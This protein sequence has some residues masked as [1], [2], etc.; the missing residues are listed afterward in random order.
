MPTHH[1]RIARV[2]E[3]HGP[4]VDQQRRTAAEAEA[5]RLDEVVGLVDMGMTIKDA[6]AIIFP[7]EKYPTM[8]KRLQAYREGGEDALYDKH[9]PPGRDDLPR[10][11]D[12]R[13]VGLGRAYPTRPAAE[14]AELLRADGIEVSAATVTVHLRQAGIARPR[15]RPARGG[16][17]RPSPSFPAAPAPHETEHPLAGAEMLRILD[18]VDGGTAAL[19]KAIQSHGR[20]LPTPSTV[21]QDDP[22]DRDAR[23]RFRPSYNRARPRRFNRQNTKFD[24]VRFKRLT[25][26]PKRL[27]FLGVSE[28]SVRRKVLAVTLSPL[29]VQRGRVSELCYGLDERLGVL[30]GRK[31]AGST[32]DKFLRDLKMADA[33][34]ALQQTWMD[35]VR[36]KDG[37]AV[38]AETGAIVVYGDGTTLPHYTRLFEQSTRVSQRGK[39]MPGVTI[40]TLNSGIGTVLQYAAFSGHADVG[41]VVAT[42]LERHP[43]Q[44]EGD[45]PTRV[46]VLD[47]ESHA[48]A[49][50][51]RL[52][53][54]VTFIIPLRSNVTGDPRQFSAQTPWI[55]WRD[56]AEVCD[57]RLELRD[58]RKGEDNLTVRV[59]GM[60]RH[61]EGRVLWFATN[62]A[63]DPFTSTQVVRIYFERWPK[64]EARYRDAK[65]RVGLQRQYG[66]GKEEIDNI[67]VVTRLDH[68]TVMLDQLED[69]IYDTTCDSQWCA[70]TGPA[71]E[72]ALVEA[73][74]AEE[75][76][77]RALSESSGAEPALLLSLRDQWSASRGRAKEA[78]VALDQHGQKT[79]EVERSLHRLLTRKGKLEQEAEE[80][81]D[82]RTIFRLD[83]DLD[84]IV[85]AFKCTF[86][87]L[88][89]RLQGLLDTK[90]E[91]NNLISRVLTL[92][93]RCITSPDGK[94]REVHIYR[95]PHDPKMMKAVER[96]CDALN[97]LAGARRVRVVDRP[98]G[99]IR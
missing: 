51:K 70:Q 84:E 30:V 22:D 41:K 28:E 40:V 91:I 16:G 1:D 37:D 72:A 15:G 69:L 52:S 20:S 58:R 4:E 87:R 3:R 17:S 35:H 76:G 29:V 25:K 31:Y 89:A 47:R 24:S 5:R 60:R 54:H 50:F 73:Q 46:V 85:L 26:D 13:I 97:S 77:A 45:E 68:L 2:R 34:P 63:H 74:Q 65:G 8:K 75:S 10:D 96:A 9:V 55:P 59:V 94:Q 83:T 81:Q 98:V 61:P 12:Q 62:A 18:E 32:L 86:L 66:Y 42:M 82:R 39:V 99:S 57:A 80:I 71:L 7:G 36:T 79:A 38:D 53:A 78:Q 21:E 90:L 48:V 64:Q 14:L 43:E 6:L 19:A 33:S 49:L 11:L 27:H 67:S 93:G 92:P 23:G 44:A 95:N 88:C 56:G